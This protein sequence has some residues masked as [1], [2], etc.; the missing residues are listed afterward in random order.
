MS[1]ITLHY[2]TLQVVHNQHLT[3][4][5]HTHHTNTIKNMLHGMEISSI[6]NFQS[7]VLI[8]KNNDCQIFVFH[9]HC[10]VLLYPQHFL[11]F[12][13]S[14][15]IIYESQLKFNQALSSYISSQNKV[16]NLSSS[17]QNQM[18][19]QGIGG[20]TPF[21]GLIYKSTCN[22]ELKSFNAIEK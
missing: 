3:H 10:T 13:K 22:M 11:K 14:K 17:I 1:C 19:N 7:I 12:V 18:H 8:F 2:T 5:A 16:I 9:L 21:V 4:T 20:L 15:F 6:L